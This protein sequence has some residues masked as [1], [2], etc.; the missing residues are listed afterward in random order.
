MAKFLPNEIL[1][2][3]VGHL[4]DRRIDP[5]DPVATKDLQSVRLVSST[6]LAI[7]TPMLFENMV[8]DLKLYRPQ[9]VNR[10]AD[11]ARSNPELAKFVHRLIVK[12]PPGFSAVIGTMAR[13][14]P[15]TQ[16]R[17]ELRAH[18][19]N[20]GM[21]CWDSWTQAQATKVHEAL[22]R[23]CQLWSC[24]QS[25]EWQKVEQHTS[26]IH[27]IAM[28]LPNLRHLENGLST[29]YQQKLAD[30]ENKLFTDDGISLQMHYEALG[31][32]EPPAF[33]YGF[34]TVLK[35]VAETLTSL[36]MRDVQ[37]HKF[38]EIAM[39]PENIQRLDLEIRILEQRKGYL[40][41]PLV[42]GSVEQAKRNAVERAALWRRSLRRLRQLENLSLGFHYGGG[43]ATDYETGKAYPVHIDDLLID[44]KNMNHNSFFP[45][46]KSLELF[47]CALRI[48]GLLSVAENH[49]KTL[50]ELKLS[51]VTFAPEDSARYW[52]E[53]GDMCK[54]A[55]P[56][57]RYLRLV[58][59]VTCRPK[60]FNSYKPRYNRGV[61]MEPTPTTWRS[62]LED[63]M[64]YEWVKGDVS[65]A[66]QEFVGALCPWSD[67]DE[68]S[69]SAL[70]YKSCAGSIDDAELR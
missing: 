57:L 3:I 31:L 42:P 40:P 41:R 8:Y 47:D 55:L 4:R 12:I 36:K 27:D 52:C 63:A 14:S 59:L 32:L 67:D 5:F 1:I 43:R 45:K 69:N 24:R 51:R 61:E 28:V 70:P 26:A 21:P 53:I 37:W 38:P 64:R 33:L 68:G 49:Q 56:G 66:V 62:G 25:S 7:A 22:V 9:D 18:S 11:F 16:T 23:E 48:P 15:E 10:L 50:R 35:S 44:P 20:L 60:R 39:I 46:L 34:K 13:T 65:G 17:S 54:N 58:K 19:M 6:M 30:I 2:P 29:Y